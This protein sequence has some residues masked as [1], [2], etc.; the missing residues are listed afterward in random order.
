MPLQFYAGGS[1]LLSCAI[2]SEASGIEA[3]SRILAQKRLNFDYNP[4][5]APTEQVSAILAERGKPV[6]TRM[7]RFGIAFP[8]REGKKRPRLLNARTDSL[9]RGSF[10]SMLANRHCVIPAQGFDGMVRGGRKEATLFFRSRGGLADRIC[11]HLG[12][13]RSE[14]QHCSFLCDPH[15]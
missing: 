5:V 3:R 8:P 14:R 13:F 4:N 12:S 15:R 9:R 1:R 6:E 2:D 11:R 10:K 7:A